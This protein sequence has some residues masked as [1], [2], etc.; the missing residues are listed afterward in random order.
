MRSLRPVIGQ[1]PPSFNK[2]PI[3]RDPM[4]KMVTF[5]GPTLDPL[6]LIILIILG[7]LWVHQAHGDMLS[8]N[9]KFSLWEILC[10]PSYG[11]F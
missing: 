10:S 7:A 3:S 1:H 11:H 8:T 6:N 2:G 5:G 4:N 9:V